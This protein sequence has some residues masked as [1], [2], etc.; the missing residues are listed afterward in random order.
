MDTADRRGEMTRELERAT[1]KPLAIRRARVA[2]LHVDPANARSHSE[3]NLDAIKGSLA[4]FGQAEPLVVHRPSGRVIGGNGRLAA[5]KELGWSECD[6]V[7]LDLSDIEATALAIA[8]NR[9]A[10]LAEWNEPALAELLGTLRAEGALEGIGF[11]AEE[12]L[13]LIGSLDNGDGGLVEDPGP[14]E[15]PVDPITRSGDLWQL[16][17]HRLLC[18]DSTKPADIQR[19]LAGERAALL[20]TDP[21]YCVDYTGNDRPI[22]DGKPSGKDWSALYREVDIKDLGV[23]MDGVFAACLPEITDDAAVYIWHAHV[24]Q[25]VI[26]ACF[27]RHG[28]LLHQILVWV[29]PTATF[30]HCFYRWKHEPCAFGW[31]RGNKPKHGYGDM[32]TVWACDWEG[33]ARITGDHPTIKPTRLFEIPMEQHTKRGAI[34][35]EPFSGSGS[36][37]IAAEKMLRR[38]RAIEISPAFVDVALRRWEQATG[39]E[40]ILEEGGRSLAE[41]A[42]QRR[43]SGARSWNP[44]SSTTWAWDRLVA[45]G[46]SPNTLE[47]ARA[48]S[49]S[50]PHASAGESGSGTWSGVLR[51]QA[52]SVC[53]RWKSRGA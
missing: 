53:S 1:G 11:S 28:L 25:P 47:R 15:P 21:P 42:S 50:V 12:V 2:S 39:K 40:A 46:P 22:H 10:E 45:T 13:D 23:F 5:M 20:S 24:Q 34:V 4:R 37:L 33:K 44:P 9:T 17:D 14:S 27:E 6:V 19:V 48:R 35:L 29:K 7:E 26:A 52:T 36:Q 18:G 51:R 41:V 32:E 31:K 49:R 16:G 38:C 3:R 30:G 8:L 43:A